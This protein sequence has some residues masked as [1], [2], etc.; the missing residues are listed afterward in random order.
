MDPLTFHVQG[1]DPLPYTLVARRDGS[2]FRMTCTCRAGIFGSWCK[3]RAALLAG[4]H[5]KATCDQP[6]AVTT[7]QAMLADS[8]AAAIAREIHSALV[9]L[10][11]AQKRVDA[12]KKQFAAILGTPERKKK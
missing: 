11:A 2:T 8:D 9:D 6:D 1:S 5:S 4:D 3:H 12:L 7:L 10:E